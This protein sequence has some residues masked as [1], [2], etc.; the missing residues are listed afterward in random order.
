MPEGRHR[1][2]CCAQRAIYPCK[3]DSRAF[4]RECVEVDLTVSDQDSTVDV[5]FE[6]SLCCRDG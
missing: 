5:V 4:R 1:A 3:P 6:Q 2:R